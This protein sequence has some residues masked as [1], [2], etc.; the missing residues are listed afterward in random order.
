MSR[1][2]TTSIDELLRHEEEAPAAAGRSRSELGWAV[3]TVA[4]A[5]ALAALGVL[6]LRF[7]GVGVPYV[8]AFTV[9]L[10]LLVQRRLV[11]QVAAPPPPRAARIRLGSA[12][13]DEV[14]YQ[15]GT[16]DGLRSAVVRWESRLE[17]SHDSADRFDRAARQR[18]AEL[19]DERLRQRHGITRGGDPARAR[20]LL[21]EPLWTFLHQPVGKPPAPRELAAMVARMEEL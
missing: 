11:R 1:D 12:H 19:A 9:V 14:S 15:W 20:A 8:L 13:E 5:A 2:D 17:W 3:R 21:G 7:F 6:L 10:A 18:L 4:Y 16:V